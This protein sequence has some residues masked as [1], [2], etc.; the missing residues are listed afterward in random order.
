[1]SVEQEIVSEGKS[2]KD[3]VLTVDMEF[4]AK[5]EQILM[6]E[7]LNA[8]PYP[9]NNYFNKAFIVVLNPKTGE[10]LSMAGKQY[11]EKERAGVIMPAGHLHP[12]L[13]QGLLSKGQPF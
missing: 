8:I 12:P 7:I 9:N 5:V 6:E 2:G 13:S 3:V 4:Q 1:M 10:I 11:D